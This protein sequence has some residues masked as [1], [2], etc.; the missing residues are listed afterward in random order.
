MGRN[1]GMLEVA[2]F[3]PDETSCCRLILKALDFGLREAL[4]LEVKNDRIS[5]ITHFHPIPAG[6]QANIHFNPFLNQRKPQCLRKGR[7]DLPRKMTGFLRRD[8]FGFARRRR[9]ASGPLP[10]G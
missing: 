9:P 6:G 2:G 1:H 3:P 10:N 5:I 8:S 7:C 4:H